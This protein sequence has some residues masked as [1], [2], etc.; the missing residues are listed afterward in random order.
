[1]YELLG[2]KGRI[3]ACTFRIVVNVPTEEGKEIT[4]EPTTSSFITL[5]VRSVVVS[6][7]VISTAVALST[8]TLYF[9]ATSTDT[10]SGRRWSGLVVNK[11]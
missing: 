5:L 10:A 7:A 11:T 3:P 9:P 4:L 8:N 2:T 6:N 1:M